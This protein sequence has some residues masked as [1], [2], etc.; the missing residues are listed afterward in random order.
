MVYKVSRDILYSFDW[1]DFLFGLS[2]AVSLPDRVF[3]R[4]GGPLKPFF[5]LSGD[6]SPQP[7]HKVTLIA[8]IEILIGRVS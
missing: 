4:A 3:L 8:D 6:V 2:D 1:D 7:F 5:G